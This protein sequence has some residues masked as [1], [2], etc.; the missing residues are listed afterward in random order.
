VQTASNRHLWSIVAIAAVHGLVHAFSIFLSPLNDEIRRYFLA[1]SVAT[2]TAFKST[3]LITYAA[4]NLFFG[5]MTNRISARRTLSVGL[6]VNGVAIVCFAFVPPSGVGL[7][8]ALWLLA[9]VGGGVYHPVANVLITR[10]FPEG[11]GRVI[12]FTGT[13]AAVGFALG[14]LLTTGLTA[15]F[16]LDWQTIALI[17][18]LFGVLASI[19]VYATVQDAERAIPQQACAARAAGAAGAAGAAPTPAATAGLKAIA[20]VLIAVIL[21]SGVREMAMWSVL[22]ISDFFL[23]GL[24]EGPG[25]TGFYLFLL[26]LPG[27]IVQ[28]LAGGLSDAI[29][30]RW[31][32]TAAFVIYGGSVAAVGV[33]PPAIVFLAYLGMGV[34]QAASI[35][36]IEAFVAD[37]AGPELRGAAYGVFFTAGIALGAL[38]PAGAGLMVDT[39]GGG[40]D[41]FRLVFALLGGAVLLATCLIPRFIPARADAM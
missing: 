27:I 10:L 24:L 16:G 37:V 32:A 30:R 2:I 28:P 14:P 21:I 38:G 3:Y 31:L 40:L 1:D 7:M 8:H 35:P 36:T 15:A 19:W 5:F 20:G 29:G 9:A 4:S 41:A 6:A 39:L 18:G 12:G 26:Y 11:K 17:F 23:L 34:G 13:G 22:D 33:L 25:Y